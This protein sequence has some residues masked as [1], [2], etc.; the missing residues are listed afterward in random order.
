MHVIKK[1]EC[2]HTL[3]FF[4]VFFDYD[5]ECIFIYYFIYYFII[6]S[7]SKIQAKIVKLKYFLICKKTAKPAE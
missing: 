6:L 5:Y 1:E 2:G 7:I 4:V 3:L